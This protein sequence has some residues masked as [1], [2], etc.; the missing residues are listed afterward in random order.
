MLAAVTAAPGG[1]PQGVRTTPDILAM[2]A[3]AP[4]GSG[5]AGCAAARC[6]ATGTPARAAAALRRIAASEANCAPWGAVNPVV[7]GQIALRQ[8]VFPWSN[9]AKSP[10]VVDARTRLDGLLARLRAEAR[11]SCRACSPRHSLRSTFASSAASMFAPDTT[12]A[13][14]RPA[15]PRPSSSAATAV[16]PRA[17]R[18]YPLLLEEAA[19]R[20]RDGGFRRQRHAIDEAPHEVER[21][22]LRVH[23]PGQPVGNRRANLD[24]DDAPGLEG[25]VKR[26]RR[27]AFDA[28]DLDTPRE[29]PRGDG[30][31]AH[32]APPPPTGATITSTSG[33]SSRISTPTVAAPAT[34]SGWLYGEM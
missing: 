7:D 29:R 2:A 4:D 25:V 1:L 3:D 6:A 28:H 10:A 32:E 21:D 20:V 23:V 31:A 17:F 11:R 26:G 8:S 13:T 33:Q 18:D 34:T 22:A 16:A 30:D 5:W 19:D 12:T 9:V 14:L 15:T 27:A 24:L